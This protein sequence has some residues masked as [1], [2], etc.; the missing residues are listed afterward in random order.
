MFA[1]KDQRS[2]HFKDFVRGSYHTHFRVAWPL[3]QLG[4]NVPDKDGFNET[5]LVISIAESMDIVVSHQAQPQT[6]H[7]RAS[8]QPL[9]KDPVFFREDIIRQSTD[10][11]WASAMRECR[12]SNTSLATEAST[13]IS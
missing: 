1:V 2:W 4:S 3:L 8:N 6:E 7:H 13:N 5:Q 12:R 9:S 10:F 11:G